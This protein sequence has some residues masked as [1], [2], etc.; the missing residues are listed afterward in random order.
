MPLWGVSAGEHPGLTSPASVPAG[1]PA[2]CRFS[3]VLVPGAGPREQGRA[4]RRA[5]ARGPRTETSHPRLPGRWRRGP[6]RAGGGRRRRAALALGAGA[7]RTG[8]RD[9]GPGWWALTARSRPVRRRLRLPA[10]R[11]LRGLPAAHLRPL[12]DASQ[13]VVLARGVFAVRGVSASPHHQLLLPG[14]ETLLQTRLPT[15]S[16]SAFPSPRRP[17]PQPRGPAPAPP[18]APCAAGPRSSE[19]AARAAR[20]WR[21]RT[22][23]ARP[24]PVGG[25]EPPTAPSCCPLSEKPALGRRVGV[26]GTRPRARWGI[27][28]PV[29]GGLTWGS[30]MDFQ[31]KAV[32]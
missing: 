18:P 14:S 26:R 10:S 16:A 23:P 17:A 32:L 5:R 12:P 31:T 11:R 30:R 3:C 20:P 8:G 22:I 29:L 25:R 24:A 28:A 1:C 6:G 13:R 2:P 7:A 9:A 27:D 21:G 19:G 15:V 4:P